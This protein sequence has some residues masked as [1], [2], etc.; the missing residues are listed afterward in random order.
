M[1]VPRV[2]LSKELGPKWGV[3]QSS[4]TPE[5]CQVD[6]RCLVSEAHNCLFRANSVSGLASLAHRFGVLGR[7]AYVEGVVEKRDHVFVVGMRPL[8]A[9]LGLVARSSALLAYSLRLGV[10]GRRFRGRYL[11]FYLVRRGDVFTL[12]GVNPTYLLRRNLVI[13]RFSVPGRFAHLVTD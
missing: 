8:I 7:D 11:S 6:L 1:V 12:H 2:G 9:V 13:Y 3:R 4:G 10:L 5:G